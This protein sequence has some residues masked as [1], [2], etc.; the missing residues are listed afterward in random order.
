MSLGKR[1]YKSYAQLVAQEGALV[2]A[3]EHVSKAMEEKNVSQKE[4]AKAIGKSPTTISRFLRGDGNIGLRTLSDMAFAFGYEL[5][6]NFKPLDTGS[7]D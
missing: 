7:E 2:Q 1:L 3:G 6:I 5:D 4:L